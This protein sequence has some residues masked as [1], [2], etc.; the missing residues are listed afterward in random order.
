MANSFKAMRTSG[1]IKRTDTGMFIRFADIHVKDG[2]NKRVDTDK[3]R[4]E[5]Y[6]LFNYLSGGG[7]VP[8]IEVI[9][10]DYGGVEVVEGHRRLAAYGRVIESGKPVEWIAI[11]PF[12]GN[13]IERT[14][15]IM[16]SNSQLK[17]TTYEESLVVKELSGFNL[18]PAEIAK[19]VNV[20]RSKVDTLLAFNQADHEVQV[21]VRDGDVAMHV[22]V[23]KVKRLGGAA[24]EE[25]K[26]DVE[27]AK[28]AGKQR[29][30]SA[31]GKFN[32]TK[33]RRLVELLCDSLPGNT[34]GGDCLLL[35]NGRIEEVMAILREHNENQ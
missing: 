12:K 8:A 18:T 2:F 23:D 7:Q 16:N 1:V 32:A 26:K 29:V 19:L 22:A 30:T 9:A 5:N 25:L 27:K 21:M 13:D 4:E 20:S 28:A 3:S 14:A 17:L 11:T 15:R 31:T 24:G 34:E 35:V 6:S 10:R 33:A